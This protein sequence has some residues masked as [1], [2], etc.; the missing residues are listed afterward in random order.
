MKVRLAFMSLLLG[1]FSKRWLKGKC[2]ACRCSMTMMLG[3]V[4][5]ILGNRDASL[6]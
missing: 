3:V 1:M 5:E 6:R 2:I 4:E